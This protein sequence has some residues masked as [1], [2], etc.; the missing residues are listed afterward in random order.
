M[1]VWG[2]GLTQSDEFCE[3]Y[4]HFM[5]RY[6][7]GDEV[8]KI[9]SDILS[10]YHN[11]FSDDDGVLHDVYFALAKA[12]WMCCA[13]SETVINK[14]KTIIESDANISFYRELEATE[15]DLKTR[16]KNL[17]KFWATLQTPRVKPRQRRIDPLDRIK[18][19]PP[20]QP[21]D[22]YAYK[23]DTGYRIVV[24]LDRFEEERL[25]EQACCCILNR[26]FSSINIDVTKEEIGYIAKYIGR[27]FIAKSKLRKLTPISVPENFRKYIPQ[28]FVE[29]YGMKKSFT[30]EKFS[31]LKLTISDLLSYVK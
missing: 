18:E 22:C 1:G 4:E 25:C 14:V 20:I 17:E 31:S 11:E 24:I 23:F 29:W 3:V 9:V 13:Q 26:T 15:A 5:E 7:N 10:E 16:R 27:E 12:E 30:R 19:L 8:S 28:E 6:N 21:G 2:M